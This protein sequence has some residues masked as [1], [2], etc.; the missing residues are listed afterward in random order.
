MPPK[1]AVTK[2]AAAKPVKSPK[3]EKKTRAPTAPSPYIIFCKETRPDIV[4]KNPNAS[5]GELGK[6]LGA[7]WGDMS[8]ADKAVSF[9]KC[10]IMISF[11][12]CLTYTL[13]T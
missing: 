3:K 11:E 1:A 10:N 9:I 4:A 6:L 5:F 8:E 2:K 7:R 12:N 13:T